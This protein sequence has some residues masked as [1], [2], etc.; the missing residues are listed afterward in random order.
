MEILN[1]KKRKYKSC[2]K[3]EKKM[4]K[5]K[6]LNSKKR[7]FNSWKKIDMKRAKVVNMI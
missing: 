3:I 2:K 4:K 5:S 7:K 6:I 1:R